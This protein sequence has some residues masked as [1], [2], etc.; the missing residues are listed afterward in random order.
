[1]SLKIPVSILAL[2][3][4]ALSVFTTLYF[5]KPRVIEIEPI[6]EKIPDTVSI[7]F[8]PSKPDTVYLTRY[9]DPDSNRPISLLLSEKTFRES[10]LGSSGNTIIDITSVVK[11][12]ADCPVQAFE[13]D[14]TFR[15]NKEMIVKEW[16]ETIRKHPTKFWTGV[17]IGSGVT[18][19]TGALIYVTTR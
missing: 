10:L 12:Y 9:I 14:I 15:P 8:G 2:V 6:V 7:K 17:A 1:M 4:I 18:I 19:G 11:A 3:C 13:N 5:V 16:E